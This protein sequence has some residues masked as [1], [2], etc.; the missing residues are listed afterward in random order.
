LDFY[1]L[2]LKDSFLK[3]ENVFFLLSLVN[4]G[5]AELGAGVHYTE[6]GMYSHCTIQLGIHKHMHSE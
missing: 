1:E 4:V 3:R 5:V 6:T 2:S